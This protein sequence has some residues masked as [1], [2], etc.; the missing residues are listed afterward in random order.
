MGIQLQDSAGNIIASPDPVAQP[1][2]QV[3]D[4]IGN[5]VDPAE[6]HIL[7]TDPAA[8]RL[9]DGTTFISSTGTALDVNISS[10]VG[11][12]ENFIDAGNSSTTPLGSGATF[13]G[14]GIEVIPYAQLIVEAFSD[15]VSAV[16]G[17]SLQRSQDNVNWEVIDNHTITA[18]QEFISYHAVRARYF[19][20]V[21]LNGTSAQAT[22]RLQTTFKTV[23]LQQPLAE[24]DSTILE[25]QEVAVVRSILFGKNAQTGL[26]ENVNTRDNK[27]KVVGE[28]QLLLDEHF[29]SSPLSTVTWNQVTEGTGTSIVSGSK[30]RLT[31]GDTVGNKTS[32]EYNMPFEHT[33]SKRN[34]LRT[35][36]IFPDHTEPDS[37]FRWGMRTGDNGVYF[38][39]LA[40]TLQACTELNGVV[41]ATNINAS[42]PTDGNVHRYDLHYRNYSAFF[43]IDGVG[44]SEFNV[45]VAPGLYEDERLASFF[46]VETT[47]GSG[48]GELD[49]EG[50][51]LSHDETHQVQISGSD[52]DFIRP[53]KTNASGQLLVQSEVAGANTTLDG[54]RFIA[55][56]GTQAHSTVNETDEV[57]IR[58]PAASGKQL[59]IDRQFLANLEAT[60][61]ATFRLY[62]GP[63]ITADGTPIVPQNALLG[64]A[65][66]SVM[67]SFFQP[68]ISAR[69]VQVQEYA[70]R[71]ESVI[72]ETAG[73]IVLPENSEMLITLEHGNLKLW[74]YNIAWIEEDVV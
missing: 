53:I 64:S 21:Y 35:G 59:I 74:S 32:I 6:E 56:S 70:A 60:G 26:L 72:D 31:G 1:D 8:N 55:I 49:V 46:E 3:A 58:N 23:A 15:V 63:T 33:F 16:G 54:T 9:T 30:V 45:G 48:G 39:L 17:L 73:R 41:T 22:F 5:L 68:T 62:E 2:Q 25:E 40:G 13:T 37:T 20:V 43:L 12:V 36:I 10:G 52:G 66:V 7:A 69:G 57:L 44:V 4:R 47:G 14:T 61:V 50:L 28:E 65:T 29:N 38:R 34:L 51:S 71:G 67:E 19:R 24:I 18:G 42:K 27:L 11:I